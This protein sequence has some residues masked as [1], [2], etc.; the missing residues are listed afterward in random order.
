E[1][2]WRG[3]WWPVSRRATTVIDGTGLRSLVPVDVLV[4][5]AGPW[6]G[7]TG[8]SAGPALHHVGA[9]VGLRARPRRLPR[10]GAGNGVTP[11]GP[12]AVRPGA[13]AVDPQVVTRE[14]HLPVVEL[15]E[16]RVRG[17]GAEPRRGCSGRPAASRERGRIGVKRVLH[18]TPVR[19]VADRLLGA[20][21]R[22]VATGVV[23]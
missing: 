20:G 16:V 6:A 9:L 22:A 4:Q 7:V 11:V 18:H 19:S 3:R 23:S 8:R 13:D 10:V 14:R 2:P 12:R 5:A 17:H 21:A 15:L 1:L